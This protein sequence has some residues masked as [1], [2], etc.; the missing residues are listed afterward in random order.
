VVLTVLWP[1]LLPG[2]LPKPVWHP[3]PQYADVLPHQ[4]LV[5]QQSPKPEPAQVA[6]PFE[7]PQEAS[8]D[9][10]FVGVATGGA[11][12]LVEVRTIKVEL[13]ALDEGT[14]FPP[15]HVPKAD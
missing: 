13:A 3:V 5:E 14:G 9:T 15:L 2:Q 7:L 8:V 12:I 10:F 6:P 11:D 4:P 1:P